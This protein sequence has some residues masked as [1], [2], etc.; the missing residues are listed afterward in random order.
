MPI[1]SPISYNLENSTPLSAVILLNILLK[2]GVSFFNFFK[3]RCTAFTVF[4]EIL[5]II[6]FFVFLSVN[7]RSTWSVFS[8]F[9][10][11]RSISQCPNSFLSLILSGRFSILCPCKR[12]CFRLFFFFTR[13]PT[14]SG[15]SIFFTFNKPRSV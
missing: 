15:K 12:L 8:F 14:F 11:T 7:V 5:R 13:L 9:P 6:S 4:P 1:F 2:L 10:I 3:Q